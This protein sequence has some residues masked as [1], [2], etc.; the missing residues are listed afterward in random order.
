MC[1]RCAR[2]S[3]WASRPASGSGVACPAQ[4]VKLASETLAGPALPMDDHDLWPGVLHDRR[5]VVHVAGL[6]D[7]GPDTG[8][9]RTH[10][11]DD[12]RSIRDERLHP[13]ACANPR[14]RLCRHSVHEDVAAL[15]QPRRQRAGLHEA[16]RAQPAIDAC[17][18]GGAGISHALKDRTGMAT[19]TLPRLSSPRKAP[20]RSPDARPELRFSRQA[21]ERPRPCPPRRSAREP[22]TASAC[23]TRRVL[24]GTLRLV[25]GF[26]PSSRAG[27][28]SG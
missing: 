16:H 13:I 9:D 3:A 18:V 2:R 26:W 17:L 19:I 8:L 7:G 23:R 4:A 5:A 21:A 12:T 14:R 15:A 27:P 1:E 22:P 28:R 24:V 25:A 20:I 6:G 11:L 10:D